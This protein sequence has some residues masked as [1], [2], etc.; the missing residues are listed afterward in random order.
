MDLTVIQEMDRKIGVKMQKHW[1]PFVLCY[2][3]NAFSYIP[4]F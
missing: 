4:Y 2:S 1:T 3:Y